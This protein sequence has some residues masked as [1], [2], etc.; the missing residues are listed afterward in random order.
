MP[1]P[2]L[3]GLAA[4]AV[5]L[6]ACQG[7]S[8]P[9]AGALP[10]ASQAVPGT[11]LLRL[12]RAGGTPK[13]YGGATLSDLG[14]RGRGRLP[15][16]QMV[17]GFDQEQGLAYAVD[18][19]GGLQSLDITTG[20]T[21]LLTEGVSGVALGPEGTL[22]VVDDEDAIVRIRNRFAKRLDSTLPNRPTALYGTGDRQLIAI[23]GGTPSGRSW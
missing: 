3:K 23:E 21:R 12:S 5:G 13:L 2:H 18:S 14:W 16:L 8:G 9:A 7:S 1:S 11:S 22:W 6:M 4:L 19:G 17:V 10:P 15:A 20:A